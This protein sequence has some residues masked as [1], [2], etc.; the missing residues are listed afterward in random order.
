L[1]HDQ[2]RGQFKASEWLLTQ[3]SK[4]LHI[5]NV[6]DLNDI[7]VI[8]YDNQLV[9]L[10]E[11]EVNETITASQKEYI[12]AFLEDLL[13]TLLGG[14]LDNVLVGPIGKSSD[15]LPICDHECPGLAHANL[16]RLIQK[17]IAEAGRLPELLNRSGVPPRPEE[18][19]PYFDPKKYNQLLATAVLN[20]V[21]ESYNNPRNE[22]KSK[23]EF[24]A[25]NVDIN[26][27][28]VKPEKDIPKETEIVPKSNES[29]KTSAMKIETQRELL[30]PAAVSSATS[31]SVYSDDDDNSESSEQLLE[32]L[33]KQQKTKTKLP[34]LTSDET[35]DDEYHSIKS[36]AT[37]STWEDNWMFKSKKNPN[38]GSN[39][40]AMLI[41]SP[42]EDVK[43]LIGDRTA[44]EI[45]SDESPKS[46]ADIP[47]VLVHN[48]TV[49]G[50]KHPLTDFIE[51]SS[52]FE[53]LTS[54]NSFSEAKNDLLIDDGDFV[55]VEKPLLNIEYSTLDMKN[56]NVEKMKEAINPYVERKVDANSDVV[57]DRKGDDSVK[58]EKVVV[59]T[60]ISSEISKTKE[61]VADTPV[62]AP[63]K[64]SK[65]D[66]P[67]PNN[68]SSPKPGN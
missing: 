15:Y 47:N 36:V 39:S 13:S 17:I 46:P 21:V 3:L 55:K 8:D 57:T 29:P 44:D 56:G 38:D 34:D 27:N 48:K 10:N 16:K 20:K 25:L 64:S 7:S 37:D 1:C 52:D 11:S 14:S 54:Q 30:S 63:R 12:R 62:P 33:I 19:L 49:I 32:T 50:G 58:V 5:S 65:G 60:G 2:R 61:T 68:A 45:N 22:I 66:L 18:H 23:D 9:E 6:L 67:S 26:Q 41:P 31:Q 35:N 40:I 4:K 51:N 28:T 24:Q 42:T 59:S 53:S 43:V